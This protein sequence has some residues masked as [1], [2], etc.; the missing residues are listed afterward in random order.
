MLAYA[1]RAH[2]ERPHPRT[3]ILIFAGHVF[4]IGAV[5]SAKMDLPQKILGGPLVVE[6]IPL[7]KDPPPKS[8]EPVRTQEQ[9]AQSTVVPI[10]DT[11][12]PNIADLLPSTIPST[13]DGRTV[14]PELQP[15]VLPLPPV[16][17][18]IVRAPAKLA[19][20]EDRLRPPYPAQKREAG[21]EATLTLRLSIDDHGRVTAVDPVGK[22]DPAF[23]AS[24]RA[25][26]VRAWRFQ[27][28]TEDGKPVASTKTVTLRFELGE[29]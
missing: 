18:E 21:E 4:A 2:R 13:G 27:P 6:T 5:M 25:H 12:L 14:I 9:V 7:P 22:A 11:T 1:P 24:A 10:V 23:L 17:H 8:H 20:S 3:L 16:T 15:P 19:T 29:A 28:A 26:L